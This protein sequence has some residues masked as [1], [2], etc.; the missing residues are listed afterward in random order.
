MIHVIIESPYAGDVDKNLAYA[1]ECLKE[2]L[3]RGESPLA[4]HLLYTQPGV[5]DDNSYVERQLGIQAGLAWIHLASEHIFY[6]DLGVSNG[7]RQAYEH[8]TTHGC[9]NKIVI[10]MLRKVKFKPYLACGGNKIESLDSLVGRYA[11][12]AIQSKEG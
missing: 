7:M 9:E 11:S 4:S 5:L 10:K 2:C 1:R 8:S 6:V 3:L 12:I